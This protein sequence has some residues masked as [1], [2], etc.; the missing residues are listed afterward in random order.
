MVS[1]ILNMALASHAGSIGLTL[2]KMTVALTQGEFQ[3]TAL[4]V[5]IGAASARKPL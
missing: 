5:R 1:D 2:L 3:K 4:A